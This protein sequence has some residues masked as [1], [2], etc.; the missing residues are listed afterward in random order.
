MAKKVNYY[1]LGLFVIASFLLA[2]ALIVIL[3]A[4]NLFQ[5]KI[6]LETYFNESVQGLS[7][8]S[9]VKYRGVVLGEVTR[10]DFTFTEYENN[11][12]DEQRKRYVLVE[13]ALQPDLIAHDTKFNNIQGLQTAITQ[14]LR[15]RLSSQGITG[16]S[17]LEIDYVDPK[18]NEPLPINWK[19]RYLY[20][21][22]TPSTTTQFMR[23]FELV[24][25][26]LQNLD[27]EGTIANWN[28]L[29][30]SAAERIEAINTSEISARTNRILGRIDKIPL[31]RLGQ[32][33]TVMIAELKDVST[34]LNAMLNNPATRQMPEDLSVA[35]KKLR[36]TLED[37][38]FARSIQSLERT[39]QRLDRITG[40]G[41][42]DISETLSN[43]QQITS[44]LRDLSETAKRY[45]SSVFFGEKPKPAKQ[46]S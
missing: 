1:K 19:P 21:P 24:F 28:R 9:K 10:I 39:L 35:A 36:T 6:M 41:E 12:P 20:I 16:I 46:G 29:L 31:D 32:D 17:Y 2:A 44:N 34:S 37:P 43:L 18:T 45:P 22:S 15:I 38:Q 14:G 40:G 5:R 3:S 33:A 13:A 11:V 4:G 30:V 27:I 42:S 25:D 23:S 8:G 26:R 7:V